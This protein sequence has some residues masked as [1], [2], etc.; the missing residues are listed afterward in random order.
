MEQFMMR[1]QY[2]VNCLVSSKL[3]GSFVMTTIPGPIGFV[4][5]GQADRRL[6]AQIEGLGDM[7]EILD[8]LTGKDGETSTIRQQV[9]LDV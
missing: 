7:M 5:N 6:T 8:G 4:R 1:F 3:T 2:F 9:P